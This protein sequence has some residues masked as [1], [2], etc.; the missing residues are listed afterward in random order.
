MFVL[1]WSIVSTEVNISDG[2]RLKCYSTYTFKV[3]TALRIPNT[4]Y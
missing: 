1:L 3:V 4:F 2:F